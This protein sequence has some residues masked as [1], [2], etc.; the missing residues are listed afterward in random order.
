MQSCSHQLTIAATCCEKRRR[1]PARAEMLSSAQP[2]SKEVEQ[3]PEDGDG[4]DGEDYSG[5][6]REFTAG[7]NGEKYQ[8][9]VHVESLALDAGGQEIAFELLDQDVGHD[10]QDGCGRRGLEV[11]R[12][13][14]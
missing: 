4:W 13:E 9:G 12:P 1:K 6:A 2:N 3:D 14:D 8:D 11:R 7:D 5:E 10:R